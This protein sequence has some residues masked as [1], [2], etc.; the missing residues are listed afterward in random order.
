[1]RA[2]KIVITMAT[3]VYLLQLGCH[4][5]DPASPQNPAQ[6]AVDTQALAFD[7][8]HSESQ[9]I[10]SNQGDLALEWQVANMPAWLTL[11]KFSGSIT[12]GADTI[13]VAANTDRENGEYSGEIAI[14]SNGGEASV[15]VQLNVRYGMNI[16]PGLG[17]GDIVIGNTYAK[18]RQQHGA[19]DRIDKALVCGDQGC[20][21]LHLVVY[22]SVGL[23]FV[24]ATGS[25]TLESSAPTQLIDL[26]SP[27]RG[28]TRELIEI[29]SSLPDVQTAYGEPPAIDERYRFYEYNSLGIDFGYDPGET[30][31]VEMII[32]R[33]QGVGML[34]LSRDQIRQRLRELE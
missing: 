16:F 14:D 34:G 12:T 4:G 10:V 8:G 28:K 1:M 29:G 15:Q 33:P 22:K 18:V 19:P 17:A 2:S 27:Y 30:Q 3:A 32:Y 13:F 23:S 5:E 9:I 7:D 11:D 6:L 31:V 24:Y 26:E 25:I 20:F 21:W